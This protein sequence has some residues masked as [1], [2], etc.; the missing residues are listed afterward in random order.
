MSVYGV[1]CEWRGSFHIRN[2]KCDIVSVIWL[3]AQQ[4]I[5]LICSEKQY[6]FKISYIYM[7]DFH[8]SSFIAYYFFPYSCHNSV[9]IRDLPAWSRCQGQGQVITSHR[10]C[11]V[12][13]LVPDLDTCFWHTGLHMNRPYSNIAP[14]DM[15]HHLWYLSNLSGII[16]PTE[17]KMPFCVDNIPICTVKCGVWS[18]FT[19][20]WYRSLRCSRGSFMI[21]NYV[22]SDLCGGFLFGSKLHIY[23]KQSLY[24]TYIIRN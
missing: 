8:P 5:L 21:W 20:P 6:F 9:H 14:G 12:Q 10:Y 24:P 4:I 22:I 2:L 1:I 15:H 11:G 13:L 19:N 17:P 16:C 23:L 7:L 18:Y 3:T